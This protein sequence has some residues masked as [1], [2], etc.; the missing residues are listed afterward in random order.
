MILPFVVKILE[1]SV[2]SSVFLL[3]NPWTMAMI[4][5]LVEIYDLP[6][7]KTALKFDVEVVPFLFLQFSK[8]V[9]LFVVCLIFHI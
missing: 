5:L 7:L 3:P 2:H 4:R 6:H 8:I 1:K 9:E